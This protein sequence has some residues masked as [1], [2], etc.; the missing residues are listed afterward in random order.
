MD[1][2]SWNRNPGLDVDSMSM[3]RECRKYGS[4]EEMGMEGRERWFSL[5]VG[6]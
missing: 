3:S 4:F 6:L 2:I 1:G 5:L